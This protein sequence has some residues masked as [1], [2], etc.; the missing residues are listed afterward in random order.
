MRILYILNTLQTGGAER[1]VLALAEHMRSRGHDVKLLVLR[2]RGANHLA[3]DL[4]VL[5]LDMRRHPLSAA[6]GYTR[7]LDAIRAFGPHVAHTHQFHGNI[8][9]RLLHIATPQ[10]P[11]ISTIHN[12]YE[13]G[14]TRRLAYRLTDF[15]SA[16]N[17]AVC[18]AA[19]DRFTLAHASPLRKMKVIT[20]G[21]DVEQFAPDAARRA[22]IR[23]DMAAGDSFVWLT[24][25]RLTPAK[26]LR[27]LLHAFAFMPKQNPAAQLWIAGE[28]SATYE[29]EL[30]QL[31]ASLAIA[32]NVRW[33]GLRSD[34]SALL[35]AADG[36]VLASAW[37]GMP[38]GLAEAMA[39][40]KPFVATD[41]GGVRELAADCGA[42]VAAADS[43]ALTEAMFGVMRMSGGERNELG[44]AARIRVTTQFN[45][46]GKVLEWERCYKQV[47]QGK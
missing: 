16:R 6:L 38:L 30:K 46:H 32:Q 25:C 5:H 18:S 45:L 43:V 8:L 34:V 21:V 26:D 31:S 19:A 44:R 13:G 2:E 36:F 17:V 15:L 40:E 23:S 47:A 4:D 33:F 29:R 27:N 20:N 3:T 24:A 12:I 7:A 1:Q 11:V 14:A 22:R 42:L 39:A 35:N 41:V 37:E 9:G 10:M 28:G